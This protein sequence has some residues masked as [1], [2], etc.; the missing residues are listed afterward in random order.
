MEGIAAIR[1]ATLQEVTESLKQDPRFEAA[2]L[3]GSFGRS[4]QDEFSDLDLWVTVA[5]A[6]VERICAKQRPSAAGAPE[7]RMEI[8]AAFGEPVI[9]HEHHANAPADGTFTAVIYASG[10][11]ID[12][13]FIPAE[14]AIRHPETLLLF[15]RDRVP[16]TPR[17][18]ALDAD[19]R[20]DRLAERYAFFWLLAV[21]AAKAWRRRDEVRFHAVIEMMFGV[22]REIEHLMRGVQSTCTRSSLAP[23]CSTEAQQRRTLVEICM[24]VA[25]L[26]ERIEATGARLPD[27]PERVLETWL[28]L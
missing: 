26:S 25:G 28:A 14:G 4:E 15:E 12:W 2:W 23:F 21:P 13:T 9:V 6:E 18:V 11:A 19:E 24:S 27:E 5:D 16:I 10:L 3:A 1:D 8:I 17:T 20:K 7:A 22:H